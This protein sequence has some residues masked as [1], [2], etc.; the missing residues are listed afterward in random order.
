MVFFFQPSHLTP[1]AYV[2]SFRMTDWTCHILNTYLRYFDLANTE[3]VIKFVESH[4]KKHS[5]TAL[6]PL[7]ISDLFLVA[8]DFTGTTT[9][10]DSDR[11]LRNTHV[12]PNK[13]KEERRRSSAAKAQTHLDLEALGFHSVCPPNATSSAHETTEEVPA[14]PKNP[15]TSTSKE[16]QVLSS[17]NILCHDRMP[18]TSTRSA[19]RKALYSNKSPFNLGHNLALDDSSA[20]EAAETKLCGYWG[21]V[22]QGLCHMAIPRGYTWGGAASEHCPVWVEMYK[23]HDR[24]TADQLNGSVATIDDLNLSSVSALSLDAQAKR[25]LFHQRRNSLKSNGSYTRMMNGMHLS[26]P[27]TVANGV[28]DLNASSDSVFTHGI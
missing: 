8:G 14:D 28:V 1:S 10:A 27:A 6:N 24:S 21:V 19:F 15:K 5:T 17:C 7:T 9:D 16:R 20:K 4:L 26:A 25:Q 11:L 3:S 13:R 22:K 23:Q 12:A 2:A 18:A